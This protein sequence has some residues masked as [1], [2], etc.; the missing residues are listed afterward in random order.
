[1]VWLFLEQGL[2]PE[3]DCF[4][5]CLDFFSFREGVAPES[6]DC[7]SNTC[8]QKGCNN[9]KRPTISTFS[10]PKMVADNLPRIDGNIV[11]RI[12]GIW[13]IQLGSSLGAGHIMEQAT[14]QSD[15]ASL[16]RFKGTLQVFFEKIPN[17]EMRQETMDQIMVQASPKN[18]NADGRKC[19]RL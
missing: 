5:D 15:E 18:K 10:T 16:S 19:D 14:G 11:E 6:F 9:R 17:F 7:Y 4:A 2:Q 8:H 3:V 1:M 13:L 12:V